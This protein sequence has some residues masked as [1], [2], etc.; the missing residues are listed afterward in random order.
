[1]GPGEGQSPSVWPENSCR[2]KLHDF[3]ETMDAKPAIRAVIIGR[4]S[5]PLCAFLV[6]PAPEATLSPVL[7]EPNAARC[8]VLLPIGCLGMLLRYMDWNHG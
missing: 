6:R 7:P 8:I 1:M 3:L 2:T 4:S 5:C